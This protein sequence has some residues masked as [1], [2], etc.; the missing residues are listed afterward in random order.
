MIVPPDAYGGCGH[1]IHRWV[2]FRRPILPQQ[3]L[4]QV[5]V[6]ELHAISPLFGS[7]RWT[8][9]ATVH[10]FKKRSQHSKLQPKKGPHAPRSPNPHGVEVVM[11]VL[12]CPWQTAT[13]STSVLIS[14]FAS[15]LCMAH[16]CLYTI[17]Y[18]HPP[19]CLRPSCPLNCVLHSAVRGLF[20][21]CSHWDTAI[22][23]PASKP[24]AYAP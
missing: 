7:H 3:P 1:R 14:L 9:A 11:T 12:P 18:V 4:T 16:R 23:T 24:K 20:A 21:M 2:R 8:A 5:W 19:L 22:K 13:L 6:T 17:Y 10:H 15:C